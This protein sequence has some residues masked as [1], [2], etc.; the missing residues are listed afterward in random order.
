MKHSSEEEFKRYLAE[1]LKSEPYG[2]D[3][4]FSEGPHNQKFKI[5]GTKKR[6]DL[7]IATNPVWEHHP[8]FP[9]LLLETKVIQKAGWLIKSIKQCERYTQLKQVQYFVNGREIKPPKL[10][11]LVTDDSWHYG[12]IYQWREPRIDYQSPEYA[13]GW[14]D[15]MTEIFDRIL[16]TVGA[17]ILRNGWFL[18][19]QKRYDLAANNQLYIG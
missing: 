12:Q 19:K 18:Y 11:L 2:H 5:K 7:L 1:Q 10:V 4:H 8:T 14:W 3:V 15:G 9:H 6:V 13:R 16:W 17:A